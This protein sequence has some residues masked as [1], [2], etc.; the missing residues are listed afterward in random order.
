MLRLTTFVSAIL[1]SYSLFSQTR[2]TLF[3]PL[4]QTP[5]ASLMVEDATTNTTGLIIRQENGLPA[6]TS[7]ATAFSTNAWDFANVDANVEVATNATLESLGDLTNT[8]GLSIGFWANHTYNNDA[9]LRLTGM[10]NVIDTCDNNAPATL[11][12]I[13]SEVNGNST[14][15]KLVIET[16]DT[17]ANFKYLLFPFMDG[18][19][20]PTTHWNN[21]KN[22][23]TVICDGMEQTIAFSEVDGSTRMEIVPSAPIVEQAAT[24]RNNLIDSEAKAINEISISPQPFLDQFQLTYEAESVQSLQLNVV[25]LLGQT[26]YQ[27]TWSVTQGF[28]Q[29]TI[30]TTHWTVGNYFLQLVENGETVISRQLIKQD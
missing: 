25:N 19:A 24:P 12:T 17:A 8:N 2:A 1:L 14:V 11:V 4:D 18:E 29:L 27:Q 10:G 15:N 16:N 20:L 26:V 7:G 9:N 13:P 5:T 23:L 28:N 6:I 3:Y 30:L 22:E 21:A